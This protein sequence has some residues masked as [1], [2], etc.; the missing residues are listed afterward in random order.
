[1]RVDFAAASDRM[2]IDIMSSFSKGGKWALRMFTNKLI[3]KDREP[4]RLHSGLPYIWNPDGSLTITTSDCEIIIWMQ[5]KF[6]MISL[7]PKPDTPLELLNKLI[8]V[9]AVLKRNDFP[10]KMGKSDTITLKAAI[11][12]T[13]LGFAEG[14]MEGTCGIL[15]DMA[16]DGEI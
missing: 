14:T 10:I 3:N 11:A 7:Q 13:A 15:W 2:A 12:I 5:G 9:R 8:K 16:R 1:M 4:Y 6:Y